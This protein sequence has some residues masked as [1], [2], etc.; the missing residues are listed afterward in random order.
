MIQ[1]LIWINVI[2]V[3]RFDINM[4][5]VYQFEVFVVQK[6]V[7]SKCGTSVRAPLHPNSQSHCGASL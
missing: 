5:Q 3:Y 4:I 7:K 1:N 6:L 2:R